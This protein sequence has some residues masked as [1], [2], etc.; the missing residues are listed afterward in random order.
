MENSLKKGICFVRIIMRKI[1][2]HETVKG[3]IAHI[4]NA[5]VRKEISKQIK[6]ISLLATPEEL[7]ALLEVFMRYPEGLEVAKENWNIIYNKTIDSVGTLPYLA[8]SPEARK[9]ILESLRFLIDYGHYD[10]VSE[11][12]KELSNIEGG[13]NVIA[14]EFETLL[15]ESRKNMDYVVVPLLKTEL[16]R[17]KLK[18]HFNEIKE[19][20]FP[21]INDGVFFTEEFFT[22]IKAL[23]DIPEFKEEYE[24]YGYFAQLYD[25][26]T[27]EEETPHR[28][29][30]ILEMPRSEQTRIIKKR[31]A[32][33]DKNKEFAYLACSDDREE[34]KLI[35]QA[36]ANGNKYQFLSC[37]SSSFVICAGE[38]VVKLGAGRRKY[39]IP[40]HPRIMMP[41]F[42][43]KYDD[44]SC[45]EVFNYGIVDSAEITDEK[46]LEI[47][48]ELES[49]GILWGDARKDNLL[50]LTQD[51][52]IPEFI[53]SKDFNVFGFLED[54][55]V[56]SEDHVALKKGDIVICDLDMLYL[57]GDP[58]YR[59][60][61][62]DAII[63]QYKF[64]KDESE[65]R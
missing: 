10:D 41:Y 45:L 4:E 23:K 39:N 35:L 42:R 6:V 63:E 36:V 25:D 8:K 18:Q 48:K 3:M 57:K 26:I 58:Q 7:K 17:K 56:Q 40:Y 62:L 21:N 27:L 50:V 61:I 5:N 34:K 38:Q 19:K 30:S 46:L 13:E 14:E 37:G 22:I 20:C 60:G 9:N 59:E 11:I 1:D 47:Y 15:E 64:D 65:E 33:Y 28:L 12:A 2:I 16:G 44:G 43:K 54:T 55:M 53:R 31:D 32:I 29:Q 49:A 51:N 24:E 52:K